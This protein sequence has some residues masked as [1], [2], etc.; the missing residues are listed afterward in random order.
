MELAVLLI[1]AVLLGYILA[2][3]LRD[4]KTGSTAQKTPGWMRRLQ[5]YF[6]PHRNQKGNE[7]QDATLFIAWGIGPGSRYFPADLR[8]WWLGLSEKEA[9]AFNHGLYDYVKGIGLKLW[10]YISGK[11]DDQPQ[12]M[13]AFIAAAEAYSDEYRRSS[14]DAADSQHR[15]AADDP[16]EVEKPAHEGRVVAAEKQASRRKASR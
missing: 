5:G 16:V 11:M 4:R 9:L 14:Q 10:D 1:G 2:G 8:E 7:E 3:V 15:A 12:M 6:S 13:G